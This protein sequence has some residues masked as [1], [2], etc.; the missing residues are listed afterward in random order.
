[1]NLEEVIVN[2]QHMTAAE[3]LRII[4]ETCG[5]ESIVLFLAKYYN[6]RVFDEKGNM[7]LESREITY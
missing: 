3:A 6:R 1:M 2:F 5:E 7:I 4:I